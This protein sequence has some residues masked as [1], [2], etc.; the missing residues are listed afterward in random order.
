[1]NWM[2]GSFVK[3][4]RGYG[5]DTVTKTCVRKKSEG[6]ISVEV[7]SVT[8]SRRLTKSVEWKTKCEGGECDKQSVDKNM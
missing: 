8:K 5:C 6:Q 4:F 3:E 7:K 2:V 1:M